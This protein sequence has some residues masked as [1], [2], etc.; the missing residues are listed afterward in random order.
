MA[1]LKEANEELEES[2]I[3]GARQKITEGYDLIK[4]RQKLVKLA[5]SSSAGWRAVDEYIKNPIASDS[6]DEKRISKVQMRAERKVKDERI[7][8]RKDMREKWRP[9]PSINAAEGSTS[10]ST[11]AAVWRSGQCYRCHKLRKDTG[12]KTVLR[13]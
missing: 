8:R 9:Y 11:T 12:R 2:R 3:Q 4:Q 13:K 10:S 7:K 5:D 1:K 6:D